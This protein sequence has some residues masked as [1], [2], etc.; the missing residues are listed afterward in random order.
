MGNRPIHHVRTWPSSLGRRKVRQFGR[1]S[2]RSSRLPL[3]FARLRPTSRSKRSF[4]KWESRST[5]STAGRGS[6]LVCAR[7]S[8]ASFRRSRKRLGGSITW[9]KTSRATKAI[10]RRMSRYLPSPSIHTCFKSDTLRL[11]SKSTGHRYRQIQLHR[12][13]S[14]DRPWVA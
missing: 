6:L 5:R 3:P 8:Y 2:L 4:G 7:Q 1:R 14:C 12:R 13:F 11:S 9:C 10:L